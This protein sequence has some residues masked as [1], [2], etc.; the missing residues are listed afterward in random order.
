MNDRQPKH[1]GRVKLRDVETGTEKIYDMSMEDD[2]VVEGDPPTKGNLLA[3]VTCDVLG[4]PKTSVV[5]DALLSLA[6]GVGSYGYVF[7]VFYPNGSLAEGIGIKGINSPSGGELVTDSSGVAIGTSQSGSLSVSVEHNFFDIE[8]KSSVLVQ[9]TGKLTEVVIQLEE[10][11]NGYAR[12]DSTGNYFFSKFVKTF[13]VCAVGGGGAGGCASTIY[14]YYN[15]GGGGGYVSNKLGV[16]ALEGV[17]VKVTIGAGG[18]A[19][20]NTEAEKAGDGGQT[21]VSYNGQVVLTAKGGTGAVNYEEK[22]LCEGANGNGVGGKGGQYVN[23]NYPTEQVRRYGTDGTGFLF[24]ESSLGV[25]GGGGGA[26]AFEG[27]SQSGKAGESDN[28]GGAPY[29][30]R[31]AVWI[32]KFETQSAKTKAGTA[33]GPGGGGGGGTSGQGAGYLEASDGGNGAVYL[34]WHY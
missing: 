30:A 25:A 3:D 17:P 1:P 21:S 4:I 6:L 24:N 19:T 13:D 31:G 10:K 12:I 8:K 29:G 15:P 23:G 33:R 34:R 26:G 20:N 32:A 11:G 22:S 9:S 18:K 2:P 14:S 5:N 7:K 27:W 28:Y 16:Q